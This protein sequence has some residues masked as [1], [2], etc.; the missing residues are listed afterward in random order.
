MK[1]EEEF[2]RRSGGWEP[3]LKTEG[4][5]MSWMSTEGLQVGEEVGVML[6]KQRKM[7]EYSCQSS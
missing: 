5:T 7:W 3:R 1:G 4:W 6:M 2:A